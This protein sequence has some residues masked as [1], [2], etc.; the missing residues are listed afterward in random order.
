MSFVENFLVGQGMLLIAVLLYVL[1]LRKATHFQW[2]RIYLLSA[3]LLSVAYPFLDLVLMQKTKVFML[4]LPEVVV[5]ASQQAMVLEQNGPFNWL[6]VYLAVSSML[7]MLLLF[8]VFMVFR[9][10][11]VKQSVAFSFFNKIVI[12]GDFNAREHDLIYSHEEVHSRQW[13]SIDVLLV[14]VF[15]LFFWFNPA[16]WLSGK[17]LR[18]VHEFIADECTLAITNRTSYQELLL[19]KHFGVNPAVLSNSFFNKSLLQKRINM[20]QKDKSKQIWVPFL[21]IGLMVALAT[22]TGC[23]KQVENEIQ[24]TKVEQEMTKPDEM[25]V[26]PGGQEALFTFIGENLKY[27]TEAK[28]AGLSGRA[29]VGFKIS[30]AGEITDVHIKNEADVDPTLYD[31]ALSVIRQMPNWEPAKKD[32]KPVAMEMTL[33]ILFQLQ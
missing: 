4:Q 9:S 13:H 24:V 20:M 22:T 8:R 21:A 19:A 1:L 2:N 10:S 28:E 29:M 32:G 11:A 25:A 31:A 18:E 6:W 26:F 12:K 7:L 16:V 5:Q 17:L 27:P 15:K 3:L 30:E 23:D 14:E 33:P